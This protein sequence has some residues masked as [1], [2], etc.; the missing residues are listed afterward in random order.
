MGFLAI[1]AFFSI[2]VP[3][4][5]LSNNSISSILT[6]QAVPGIVV[7]GV[8][9]LMISGEFDLSIGSIMGV[10]SLAFLAAAVNGVHILWTAA[11]GLLAD[12]SLG[13]FNGLLLV[14]ARIPSF[15][16]TL[17]TMLVF[18]AIALTAISGG[19]IIRYADY[20]RTDPTLSLS[21]LLLLA[22]AL[23]LGALTMWM[24][25]RSIVANLHS[26]RHHQ[27]LRSGFIFLALVGANLLV[28]YLV[29]VVVQQLGHRLFEP[30]KI[31]FFYLLNGRL[32][33][34]L[35]G[36]NYRISILWWAALSIIFSLLLTQTRYGN[37]I[38][39]TGGNSMAA[40]AQGIKTDR[41]RVLNFVLAGD[42]PPWPALFRSPA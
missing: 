6:S 17:G 24:S 13:L 1:F 8:T 34:D 3:D 35:V 27:E 36:G 37:A 21:P 33:A 38:F 19:R 14:W 31:S 16:I 7:T 15:I 30:L 23:M 10:A 28:L 18:R 42:W 41:V 20:S 11:L 25:H 9:L 39:A 22:G 40:R 2:S 12:C 29:L 4:T 5:F 32:P 26:F